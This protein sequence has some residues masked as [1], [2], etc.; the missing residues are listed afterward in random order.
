MMGMFALGVTASVD[1]HGTPFNALELGCVDD[2]L[3][4]AKLDLAT[5]RSEWIA[6]RCCLTCTMRSQS[7]SVFAHDVDAELAWWLGGVEIPHSEPSPHVD[8]YRDY[9][10]S[11]FIPEDRPHTSLCGIALQRSELA[12]IAIV[13]D[14]TALPVRHTDCPDRGLNPFHRRCNM[15]FKDDPEAIGNDLSAEKLID[16]R[17]VVLNSASNTV[18][19]LEKLEPM[20]H[21]S[22]LICI[23][24]SALAPDELASIKHDFSKLQPL[25]HRDHPA[26]L[27]FGAVWP[28][29]ILCGIEGLSMPFGE[30]R[31]SLKL[32]SSVLLFD[33]YRDNATFLDQSKRR[34]RS[35]TEHLR[36]NDHVYIGCK[37]SEGLTALGFTTCLVVEPA[38]AQMDT[39]RLDGLILWCDC[40]INHRRIGIEVTVP[41][42]LGFNRYACVVLDSKVT[43]A[44][45]SGNLNQDPFKIDGFVH[46]P[47]TAAFRYIAA[48]GATPEETQDWAKQ[49][50]QLGAPDNR[51]FYH[52]SQTMLNPMPAL[53]TENRC[54]LWN[55]PG[56][57]PLVEGLVD[58]PC[59]LIS[60]ADAVEC[61]QSRRI[62][63]V[64][65]SQMRD[66]AFAMALWLNDGAGK[67]HT[68]WNP[69]E[70]GGEDAFVRDISLYNKSDKNYSHFQVWAKEEARFA[71]EVVSFPLNFGRF[72]NEDGDWRID[73]YP[74]FK[75]AWDLAKLIAGGFALHRYARV[76]FNTGLHDGQWIPGTGWVKMCTPEEY[77]RR[78]VEGTVTLPN[79]IWLPL[80]EQCS[81][82]LPAH[83]E[84]P[85]WAKRSN[86]NAFE[87]LTKRGRP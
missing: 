76:F 74:M 43:M 17:I 14:L 19:L 62:A 13:G 26:L 63:F 8:L 5:C 75:P 28:V 39:L 31:E 53:K 81:K 86:E 11:G 37:V 23:N 55:R 87:F 10:V 18:P 51:R 80:N 79:L 40:A 49:Y 33:H 70:F 68:W 35:A 56:R 84:Q 27:G 67:E 22:T 7:D 82:K 61:L 34:N 60:H 20:L 25:P 16:I 21:A 47:S 44:F 45:I 41:I 59:P 38:F 77:A 24:P 85:I 73:F 15:R 2:F 42:R 12:V 30:D 64:G 4:C 50:M 65:D 66:L 36:V 72:A 1:N 58:T 32:G 83:P 6:R 52:I 71:F 69:Y 48:I 9:P 29:F 3:S 54:D 57:L 46:D 78:H